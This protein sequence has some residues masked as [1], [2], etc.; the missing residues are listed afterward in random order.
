MS[1]TQ[2]TVRVMGASKAQHRIIAAAFRNGGY[3]I[4]QDEEETATVAVIGPTHAPMQKD[5]LVTVAKAKHPLVWY[6]GT[7]KGESLRQSYSA[8]AYGC[9]FLRD[10]KGMEE[11]S[12]EMVQSAEDILF[13]RTWIEGWNVSGRGGLG[14]VLL[15]ELDVGVSVLDRRFRIWYR[16][17]KHEEMVPTKVEDCALCWIAYHDLPLRVGPCVPC[18]A[19]D[20]F[21]KGT[22]LDEPLYMA[23]GCGQN[24]ARS[25]R[26]TRVRA[27]PISDHGRGGRIVGAV[28]LVYD[29]MVE[30]FQAGKPG[31][32]SAIEGLLRT[33]FLQ[34]YARARL[35]IL[36]PDGQELVGHTSVVRGGVPQMPRPIAS[37]RLPVN[38][39]RQAPHGPGE[40]H[41]TLMQ[42]VTLPNEPQIRDVRQM[43]PSE[44][45]YYKELDKDRAPVWADLPVC[46]PSGTVVGKVVID[47]WS[48]AG[49]QHPQPIRREDISGYEHALHLLGRLISEAHEAQAVRDRES[50]AAGVAEILNANSGVDNNT[51]YD[52]LCKAVERVHGVISAVIRV[53]KAGKGCRRL[54]KI[55]GFGAY[56]RHCQDS[57]AISPDTISGA[58]FLS[59]SPS[60]VFA[61]SQDTLL[62][63]QPIDQLTPSQDREE[64]GRIHFQRSYPIGQTDVEPVGVLSVQC[65]ESKCLV[66]NTISILAAVGSASLS[67]GR[68]QQFN[69]D[70]LRCL[71]SVLELHDVDT[72]Q[73]SIRVGRIAQAIA[74][75]MS[76]QDSQRAYLAGCLHDIGKIGLSTAIIREHTLLTAGEWAYARVHVELGK[77]ILSEMPALQDVCL[78][79]WEHHKWFDGSD[80]YPKPATDDEKQQWGDRISSLGRIVAVADCYEAMTSTARI[81]KTPLTSSEA[82][83]AI[84]AHSGTRFCPKA[85]AAF[86]EAFGT[87]ETIL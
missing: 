26:L 75:R 68:L 18:P 55:T 32:D 6:K 49:K 57:I 58:A 22:V 13:L 8:R 61:S 85:V 43:D 28:E 23:V 47:R 51:I 64:L 37:L 44:I 80:G 42:N 19:A 56:E 48:K 73:H 33:A 39:V 62:L 24:D 72:A 25:P 41:K 86:Q 69:N 1:K 53:P 63:A 70:L 16:N 29:V 87:I 12:E 15:D 45:Y 74:A 77:T 46:N 79:A 50:V 52:T 76:G 40:D 82:L 31:F 36:T 7:P 38:P 2:K 5:S 81:Y 66:D 9:F 27:V 20:L 30:M 60:N 34:E 14:S 4:L 17:A 67:A 59:G 10:F 54:V 35:F 21:K 71:L 78:A 11:L 65:S 84:V 83:K 3:N